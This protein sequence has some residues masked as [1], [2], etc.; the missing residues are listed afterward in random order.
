MR[1]NPLLALALVG[2]VAVCPVA[3]AQTPQQQIQPLLDEQKAA[4]A[5][6]DTDR[7][8][9]AYLRSPDLVFVFNGTVIR[10][11]DALREQQRI[12]WR[13]GASDVTYSARSAPI[14]T[15]LDSTLVIVTSALASRRTGADGAETT[16]AFAV[17]AV[18][19]KRAE[20]W[21]IVSAHESTVR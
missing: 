12:W 6:H 4:A 3:E 19:Q 15:T 21:R 10:G 16:S 11:W 8:M 7:F 14:F 20:G 13:N 5:D 1:R 17:T 9:A 18:W 2:L